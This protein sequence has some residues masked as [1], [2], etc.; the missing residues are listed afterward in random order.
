MKITYYGHACV[1]VEMANKKI[2][3]DPFISPNDLAKHIDIQQITAD[4]IL[5][6]HGHGDHLADVEAIAKHS[7][8][9]LVSNY[10]IVTWFSTKGI[11]KYHPMNHGGAW[12]F[13][14][15]K[16]KYV[17]AVHS[18]GLP[19]GTYGGNPGGFV[20]KGNEQ[21]FYFA[22]DTAL[23]TDMQLIPR[24]AQLDLAILPIG[25]NFT[26]GYEDAVIA[27]DFVQCK[28]V[29][30]IHY[31]TFPYIKIDHQQAKAAFAQA[32]KELILLEIGQSIVV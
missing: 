3:F 23:S 14:F 25:D 4:Y 7:G 21:S 6:S 8:S 1:M 22:G 20:I 16:V 26:M 13:D 32:G 30:G 9:T 24:F 10:E 28:R 31:D 2:L 18:S 17:N 15:G 27:A 29:L 12:Q 19:D 11:V 5:V